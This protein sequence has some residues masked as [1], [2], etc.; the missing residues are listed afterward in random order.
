MFSQKAIEILALIDK[1]ADK[2]NY[3][4]AVAIL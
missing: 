2:K 4:N 1:K 3:D